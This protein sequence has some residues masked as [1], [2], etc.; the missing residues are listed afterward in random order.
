MPEYR[1][2]PV[3]V[4]AQGPLTRENALDIADWCRGATAAFVA[5]RN[6]VIIGTREGEM[7]A[8]LGDYIIRESHPT[9]DRR[10]YPCKPSIFEATYESADT[11]DLT[12]ELV[13]ASQKVLGDMDDLIGQSNGVYGL[14]MNGDDA[15]WTDLTCGGY[16]E[17]WLGSLEALRAVLAK[18]KGEGA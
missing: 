8:E 16:M 15:P 2:K 5:N 14:H 9:D 7:R 11:P 1:K 12:A 4:E 17:E 6:H 10:F 3:I 18:V 13:E